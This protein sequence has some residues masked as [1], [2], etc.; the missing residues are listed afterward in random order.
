[1][2]KLLVFV[3]LLAAGAGAAYHFG[4]LDRLLPGVFGARLIPKDSKLLAYFG[5]DTHELGILQMTEV[6]F[7]LSDEARQKLEKDGRE[8]Y[9]KTGINVRQDVDAIAG[10]D[11]LA[12]ARGRF[13]WS[14]LGPYLQ[15]EGYTLAELD[16]VPAAIKPHAA[17]L[18]LDGNYLLM[19]PSTELKKALARKREGHGL[20]SGSPIVKAIDELGWKHAL[21]GGVVSGS[22]FSSEAPG[23]L[24]AQAVVGAIDSA[25]EGF[26]LRAVALTG[27][28]EQA[29]AMQTWLEALRKTALLQMAVIPKPELR[30]V[31]DSLERA[32]IETDSQG[33]LRGAI[34]FPYALVDQASANLSQ[35]Q[36]PSALQS[37]QLA[38]EGEEAETTPAPAVAAQPP[39]KDSSAPAAAAVSHRL[40]WKPPVFG[41]VLLVLTLLTMG[42]KARPGL[43]NVLLHPLYLLPFLVATLGVFVFRWTGY[44]GGVFELLQLPMPEWH[45]FLSVPLAQ[46][47]ALSA[48]IPMVL[49]ILSGPVKLLRRFAAG[50]AVG[51]SGYLVT[52][53][54]TGASVALIPP[55]YTLLWFAGNALA[56]LLL[57]RLTIPPRVSK[58]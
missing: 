40:D 43:F 1:M 45:R 38:D 24:Q 23:N 37:M 50:L 52:E 5:P 15:S 27:S 6:N 21:V 48:A 34:R 31:R 29:E 9:D 18:A 7:P 8:L 13:D 32:T 16:G 51:F 12:V 17:D 56:A 46:P 3:V 39:T 49:A 30:T 55:A 35:A 22:R 47:V 33:R 11:G 25:P 54:L 58:K 53:A 36:L 4:Y 57:A 42:A 26:E 44:S 20:E 10:V 19:G 2:K 41:V 28:K 14:R